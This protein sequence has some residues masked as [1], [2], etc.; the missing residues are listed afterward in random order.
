MKKIFFL[1]IQDV[2]RIMN[3]HPTHLSNTIKEATYKSP[4]DICNEKTINV[5]KK[6][7]ENSEMTISKIANI[8][9]FEPTNIS[10]DTRTK[11]LLITEKNY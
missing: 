9:T 8:L 3:I 11:L 10:K 6:I 4:C 2:A 7:L 5:A 1:G